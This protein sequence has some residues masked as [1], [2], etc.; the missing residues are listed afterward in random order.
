MSVSDYNKARSPISSAQ[1]QSED[2]TPRDESNACTRIEFVDITE[3]ERPG[4]EH[5]IVTLTSSINRA[6]E[7]NGRYSEYALRLIRKVDKDGD[8]TSTELEIRSPI[9]R[10]ILR[11]ILASYSFL[12]LAADPIVIKKPYDALFHFRHEIREYYEAPERTDEEKQHLKVLLDPFIKLHISP[13]E[14]IY[15]EDIP[16]GRIRFSLLWTLFRAEDDVIY[17]TEYFSQIYRVVHCEEKMDKDTDE[18]Y[19]LMHVWRWGYNAGKFGPAAETLRIP[20]FS[21]TRSITQLVLFPM[22]YLSQQDREKLYRRI[23]QRG[24]NWRRLIKPAHRQYDG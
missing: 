10:Q 12:N 20:Y 14:K 13:T 8:A 7:D 19:F 18:P 1:A 24:H 21:S 23:V 15:Q 2:L 6:K 5:P 16:K 9:L 4:G 17:Q 3:K 11:T 22:K